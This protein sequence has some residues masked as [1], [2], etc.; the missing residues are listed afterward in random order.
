MICYALD[1][2][3]ERLD[4]AL[5]DAMADAEYLLKE[6]ANVD[7]PNITFGELA[8]LMKRF[9]G[10][11]GEIVDELCTAKY[12]ADEFCAVEYYSE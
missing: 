12:W 9:T 1:E 3:F 4:G 8:Q 7:Y 11:L 6:M 5:D 2:N 10:E